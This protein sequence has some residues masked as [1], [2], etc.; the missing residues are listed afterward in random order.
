L[1]PL[2]SY[3][4]QASTQ[5]W[6]G[7]TSSTGSAQTSL[8]QALNTLPTPPTDGT[9]GYKQPG[10][11]FKSEFPNLATAMLQQPGML[12]NLEHTGA[13]TSLT[14]RR[15]AANNLPN[16]ELPAPFNQQLQQ[17]YNLPQLNALSQNTNAGGGN[18]LT[19][20]STVPGDN[21]SPLTS[22]LNGVNSNQ[23][24]SS[25]YQ[26]G[27]PPLNTGLTPIM[28]AASGNTPQPWPAS[29]NPVRGLFSP[30][31]AGSLPRG[32]SNS[33]TAG[34][35][36]P[37][38]PYDLNSLPPLPTSMSMGAPGCL[39][40][41]SAHQQASMHAFMAQSQT[42]TQTPMSATTTQPSP[43]NGTDSFAQRPQSTP[44][45]FYSQSQPSS[46]QQSTFPPFNNQS[47]PVQQS[48][49]SAPPQGSRISPMSAQSAPFSPPVPQ[50]SAYHRS[51]YAPFLPA[52]S[53]PAQVG[54]PIMSNIHNPG[55]PMGLMGMQGH[56]LPG[57]LMPGYN[58][59]HAAQLQQQMF[60]TPQQ[61]PHNERPFKCDQCPQSFNRNH[62]LK[63]HKRI[64]L[65]V[66][67]FPCGYCEKSFS[68]KDA[69]K[70]ISLL[71]QFQTGH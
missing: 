35:S 57:G 64:H 7:A 11:A 37:P 29:L 33:P 48:P 46:A 18:L 62:D 56:G 47:S 4:Q 17:K 27:W 30:S 32:E 20:P 69:L 15:P 16:F 71:C 45:T 63:R 41:V 13:P 2:D 23:G 8:A 14:Q 31:L 6:P 36:L 59:G 54:G 68:R 28:G 43:I 44:S 34:E 22:L 10:Q 55:N 26:Y 58:S 51:S 39:P 12:S 3:Q 53:A 1:P 50:A 38:P 9:D 67:P 21:L 49:M 5:Y 65:A 25:N 40:T 66:K 42:Q 61:T 60:G 52:M 70:V 19:P 24:Q